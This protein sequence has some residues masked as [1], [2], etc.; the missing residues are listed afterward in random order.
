MVRILAR[1]GQWPTIGQ[2]GESD[3]LAESLEA[4]SV[5]VRAPQ[6]DSSGWKN[7]SRS[8]SIQIKRRLRSR[9][10]HILPASRPPNHLKTR[11]LSIGPVVA[12]RAIVA[13]LKI[14]RKMDPTLVFTVSGRLDVENVGELCH[15]IDAEPAGVVVVLDLTDLVLADRDVVRYLRGYETGGRIVLRNCPAYIRA[16]M[17]AEE[18]H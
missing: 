1:S 10:G 3:R 6:A 14:Q 13:L 5:E 8:R 7:E 12:S 16:W 15:L 18:N 4:Q 11:S 2:L 9:I 17:A